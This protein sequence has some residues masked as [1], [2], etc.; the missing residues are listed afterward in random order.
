[1]PGDTEHTK[2]VSNAHLN[3]LE[4]KGFI[5]CY[6]CDFNLIVGDFNVDFYRGGSLWD[7]LLDCPI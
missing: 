5:D 6:G 4:E 3:V 1:M 7:L 2:G